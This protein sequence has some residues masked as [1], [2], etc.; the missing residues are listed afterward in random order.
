MTNWLVAAYAIA[1]VLSAWAACL[2]WAAK[3]RWSSDF[4]AAKD[5]TIRSKDTQIQMLQRSKDEMI[6]AKDAQLHTLQLQ[7]D[8]LRE[9][10]PM[11]IREYFISMKER[12]EEFND[13]LKR[14]LLE[15][16]R[17]IAQKQE[18][19]HTLQATGTSQKAKI[20]KLEREKTVLEQRTAELAARVA[21]LEKEDR[22]FA[23]V[24]NEWVAAAD[25]SRS[26]TDLGVRLPLPLSG[27]SY[28]LGT[29][30]ETAVAKKKRTRV[31]LQS[32][33]R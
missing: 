14:Q 2:A 11:K 27:R 10:T 26:L 12:L 22:P 17:L 9:L 5:E 15:A 19:I 8:S 16:A 30:P 20:E 7:L 23:Q 3:L 4:A 28:T 18:E 25:S 13:S 33:G 24:L 32:G 1:A 6:Q 21:V 29:L 31:D